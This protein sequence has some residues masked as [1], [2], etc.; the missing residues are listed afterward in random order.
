MHPNPSPLPSPVRTRAMVRAQNRGDDTFLGICD[1]HG[2][3]IFD[4]ATGACL[5]CLHIFCNLPPAL[6]SKNAGGIYFFANCE[7]CG[8]PHKHHVGNRRCATCFDSSGRSRRH[9]PVSSRAA[10]RALGLRFYAESCAR[11]GE[12]TDHWVSNGK[13]SVCFTAMGLERVRPGRERPNAR[14]AA[15]RMGLERYMDHCPT[16]G[17]TWFGVRYGACLTCCTVDGTPRKAPNET[18]RTVARRAGET[19]YKGNC[20]THGETPHYTTRGLCS[21]CYNSAGQKRRV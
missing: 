21:T 5:Q 16:H 15:R 9:S 6:A 2:D 18:S 4:S 20:P 3:S 11:C 10:A 7:T 14:A 17:P 19:F 1:R 12:T 13:C 8:G